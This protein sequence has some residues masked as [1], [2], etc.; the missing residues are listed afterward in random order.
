MSKKLKKATIRFY[1]EDLELL[2]EYYPGG[3]NRPGINEMIREIIA[4][5]VDKRLRPRIQ[6]ENI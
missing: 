6:Q 3:Y 2:K 1:E 4:T 5:W